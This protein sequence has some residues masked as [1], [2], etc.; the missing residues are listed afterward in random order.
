MAGISLPQLTYTTVPALA[1]DGQAADNT[2]SYNDTAL[3]E[4]A[5]VAAGRGVCTG[6]TM[7]QCKVPA[8]AADVTNKFL[9]VV[10]YEAARMPTPGVA[11]QYAVK[12]AAPILRRGKVWV[13]PEGDMVDNGPVFLVNGSGAGTAGKW[14]GDANTAAATQITRAIC[15]RGATAAS[16]L[17]ALLEFNLP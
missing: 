13:F 5:A 8:V 15:R 3:V 4:T 6:T 17:P 1:F 11:A 9:G 2:L 10:L 16:G 12:A 7:D 14:R